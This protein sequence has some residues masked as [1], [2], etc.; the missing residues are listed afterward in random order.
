MITDL[1]HSAFAEMTREETGASPIKLGPR[2]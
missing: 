1:G 2:E